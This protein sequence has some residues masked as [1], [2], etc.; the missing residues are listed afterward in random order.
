MTNRDKLYRAYSD[1]FTAGAR[2]RSERDPDPSP[3]IYESW[4]AL[5]FTDHTTSEAEIVSWRRPD[6]NHV[7]LTA[8]VKFAIKATKRKTAIGYLQWRSGMAFYEPLAAA[9]TCEYPD[10][11]TIKI[12]D[13]RK[14]QGI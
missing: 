2:S 11:I 1:G 6:P 12:H 7:F 13:E 8:E 5:V 14:A 9:I 3:V 10:S 4:M